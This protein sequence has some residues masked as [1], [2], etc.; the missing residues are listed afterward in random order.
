MEFQNQLL[1]K[2][3]EFQTNKSINMKR[4]ALLISFTLLFAA[5]FSQTLQTSKIII[6]NDSIYQMGQTNG[7]PQQIIGAPGENKLL[8]VQSLAITNRVNSRLYSPDSGSA[9]YHI[10]YKNGGYWYDLT[11]FSFEDL[12]KSSNS[13]VSFIPQL[14]QK[15][16]DYNQIGN[17]P[18]MIKL[19]HPMNFADGYNE[20]TV[21]ITYWILN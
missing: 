1:K 4:V 5:C 19:N 20:L 12:N 3:T 13:T 16:W 9:V 2:S 18:L 15:F 7:R 14:E 17:A 8:S 10:G 6:R 11:S 21:Y